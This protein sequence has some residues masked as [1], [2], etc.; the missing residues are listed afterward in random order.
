MQ[1]KLPAAAAE[2]CTALSA[3]GLAHHPR[4]RGTEAERTPTHAGVAARAD[5]PQQSSKIYSRVESTLGPAPPARAQSHT[6]GRGPWGRPALPQ[7]SP[8]PTAPRR[9]R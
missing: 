5:D 9:S 4:T 3:D 2:N 8:S 1:G 6:G 7:P